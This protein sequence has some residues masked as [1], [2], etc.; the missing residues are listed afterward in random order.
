MTKVKVSKE[1]GEFLNQYQDVCFNDIHWRDTLLVDFCTAYVNGIEF[2]DHV[3]TELQ[4][5]E[6]A[7]ILVRGYEPVADTYTMENLPKK[8]KFTFEGEEFLAV[9]D[10]LN[11][12][13]L[14]LVSWKDTRGE[15][16][17]I[18]HILKDKIT[19]ISEGYWEVV[20]VI[21]P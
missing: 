6:L 19:A 20:E 15:E 7:E 10:M 18:S 13:E 17:M 8:F 5:I 9:R 3:L 12:T 2:N 14:L 16:C 11:S 21:E 4:P 1:L